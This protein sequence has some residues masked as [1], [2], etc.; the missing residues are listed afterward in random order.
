MISELVA[1]SKISRRYPILLSLRLR[2]FLLNGSIE[3]LSS[4]F[5]LFHFEALP[6]SATQE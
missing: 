3:S 6:K 2:S 1:R 5:N 4:R